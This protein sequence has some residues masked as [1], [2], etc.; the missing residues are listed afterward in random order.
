MITGLVVGFLIDIAVTALLLA[1]VV[2]V[3][4]ALHRPRPPRGP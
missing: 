1:A 4:A 2:L 3:F